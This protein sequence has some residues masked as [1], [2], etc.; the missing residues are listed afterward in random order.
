[1]TASERYRN[2][3][4]AHELAVVSVTPCRCHKAQNRRHVRR[5]AAAW[6]RVL[7]RQWPPQPGTVL[8]EGCPF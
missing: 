3:K 7:D 8:G 6:A 2:R 5:E 1:M 4:L